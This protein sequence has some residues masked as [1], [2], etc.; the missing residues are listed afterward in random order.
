M[1]KNLPALLLGLACALGSCQR[2]ETTTDMPATTAD[3]VTA[4]SAATPATTSVPNASI[5]TEAA[6]RTAVRDYVQELPNRTVYQV[7]SASVVE[8]DAQ[9]QVLVPR[10]DWA[11]RMPNKAAF[12][13]DKQTGV[14]SVQPVK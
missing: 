7:D 12:N 5:N 14:V 8:S 9:F 10:T 13:V 4:D 6:A 11:G 3:T 2:T 1:M